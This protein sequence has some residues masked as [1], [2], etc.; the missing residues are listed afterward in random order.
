MNVEVLV[1]YSF[2]ALV[3]LSA[4]AVVTGK[5]IVRSVF[6]LFVTLFSI[7]GLYIFS[8]ADFVAVTQVVIYAGGILIL[9]LFAFMLSNKGLLESLTPLGKNRLLL[10]N[11]PALILVAGFFFLLAQTMLQADPIWVRGPADQ[12][13]QPND[14]ST[15][16]IGVQ[17]M[18]RYLLPFEVVS[19]FLL[20]AL[21]GAAHL[22][23][24]ERTA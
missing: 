10:A 3:L 21:I 11:V 18:T 22:S 16:L 8:L 19:V 12:H 15:H 9:M 13:F 1:F 2:A 20:M 5:N 6:L 4:L 7:A 23:R 14:N 17:L 24:K